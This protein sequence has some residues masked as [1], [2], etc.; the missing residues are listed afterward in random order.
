MFI[1]S[2]FFTTV[3]S[4]SPY[5]RSRLQR[6][7]AG[8]FNHS[9]LLFLLFTSLTREAPPL[10]VTVRGIDEPAGRI[11]ELAK[12]MGQAE[13]GATFVS[14]MKT[15]EMTQLFDENGYLVRSFVDDEMQYCTS[16]SY[17]K[18]HAEMI[19]VAALPTTH[20]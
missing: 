11:T 9:H 6:H 15:P 18:K 14:G 4:I 5:A 12:R 7:D 16:A 13:N 8:V 2:S 3:A 1:T 17:V 10:E 20:V 19:Q